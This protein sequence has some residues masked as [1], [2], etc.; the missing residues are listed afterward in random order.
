MLKRATFGDKSASSSRFGIGPDRASLQQ[1]IVA[2]SGPRK[3][4]RL[5]KAETKTLSRALKITEAHKHHSFVVMYPLCKRLV[6][7]A[8]IESYEG[9]LDR[10]KQQ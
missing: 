9:R 10:T 2:Y 4:R 5:L 8:R 3:V 7:Q 6:L 1:S